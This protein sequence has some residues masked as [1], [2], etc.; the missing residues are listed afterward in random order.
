MCR[1]F[2]GISGGQVVQ[3]GVVLGILLLLLGGDQGLWG[4]TQQLGREGGQEEEE[5]GEVGTGGCWCWW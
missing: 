5:E 1:I 3:G 2:C 4:E